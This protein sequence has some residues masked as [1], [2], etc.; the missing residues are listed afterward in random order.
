MKQFAGKIAVI[1][2]G[3]TG[4][5]RELARMLASEGCHVAICDVSE[6]AM[7]QTKAICERS[8]PRGTRISTTVAD[9]ADEAQMLAFRDAVARDH[10][11]DHIRTSTLINS[12]RILGRDPKELGADQL[13]RAR[14]SILRLGFDVA[15][16]TNDEIRQLLVLRAEIFRDQAPMSA[17]EAAQVILDGVREERW[18]ILVGEDARVLDGM[19]RETPEEAYEPAFMGRFVAASGWKLTPSGGA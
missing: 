10:R 15:A 3:G 11:T 8:A 12:A 5:G 17:A 7:A 14:D 19:V 13:A 1:T 9:V 16:A 18:R 4:M 6:E 2:G